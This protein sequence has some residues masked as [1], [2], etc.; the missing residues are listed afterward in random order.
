MHTII[1]L[2]TINFVYLVPVLKCAFITFNLERVIKLQM[3]GV[4]DV[5]LLPQELPH[6]TITSCLCSGAVFTG[7][8]RS[9]GKK[10]NVEVTIQARQYLQ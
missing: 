2:P 9:K 7:S 4:F 6:T 1:I 3:L 8:Q 5:D 10:Y